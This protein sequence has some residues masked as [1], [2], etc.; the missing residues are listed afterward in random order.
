M[1]KPI[2]QFITSRGCVIQGVMKDNSEISSIYC[3]E[4][5]ERE[6]VHSFDREID[7]NKPLHPKVKALIERLKKEHQ[8]SGDNTT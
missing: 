4:H 2:S 8:T 5:Q 6:H 7:I 3:P 1:S